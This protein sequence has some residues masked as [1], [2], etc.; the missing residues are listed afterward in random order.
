VLATCIFIW[1][2]LEALIASR[3]VIHIYF[4]QEKLLALA[5]KKKTNVEPKIENAPWG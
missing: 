4:E 2:V 3:P 5:K 1:L